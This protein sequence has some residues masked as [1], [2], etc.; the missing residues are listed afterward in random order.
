MDG[1]EL[2]LT[3][4]NWLHL[5]AAIFRDKGIQKLVSIYGKWLSSSGEC[6][7]K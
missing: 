2:K 7:E 1:E 6:V 5:Q 4:V 3:V